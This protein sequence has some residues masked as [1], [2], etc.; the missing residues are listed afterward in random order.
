[1]K[2]YTLPPFEVF[3]E[4]I[5][6]NAHRPEIG[7]KYLRRWGRKVKNVI[8]DSGVEI[9]RDRNVTD[10]PIGHIKH[11][12]I[13]YHQVRQLCPNAHVMLV[14]PDYPDDYHPQALWLSEDYT[15]IERTVD[16]VIYCVENYPDIPWIIPIQGHYRKPRSIL[17]SLKLLWDIFERYSYVALA[18][19]CVE[20]RFEI[21]KRSYNLVRFYLP[22]HKIHIF[23]LDLDYAKRL[24]PY[25]F[26]SLAYTYPRQSGRWSCKNKEERITYFNLYINALKGIS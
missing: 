18:N 17:R 7:L 9:F 20:R 8:I 6:I 19:L 3:W 21:V 5:I 13:I 11:M 2:F 22:R 15:N 12:V 24:R 26:D 16:N 4:N 23:G 10:Y 14:C 1:M 25:S